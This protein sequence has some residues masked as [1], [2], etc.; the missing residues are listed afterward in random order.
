MN[1]IH[2][3]WIPK[4]TQDFMQVGDF[5]LW[6]ES[7]EIGKTENLTLHPQHLPQ[8][9][10][11]EFLKN[12]LAFG[13]V[14]T[15]QGALLSLLLPTYAGKPLPSQELQYSEI[16]DTVILQSWQ[17]YAYPLPVPLKAINNI[18]FLCCYQASNSRIGSDFLFWYYFSQSLKQILA[19]DQYI[20]L[21]LSKKAGAKIEL[22]RRWQLVSSNYESLI[23]AA[24]TQMPLAC[25]QQHQPESLLRHFAE[26]VIDE[27]ITVA[28][29]EI[30]QIFTKKIQGDFL[31]TIL[32]HK[33]SAESIAICQQLPDDFIHWQ[34]WQQ[35]LLGTQVKS[36]LHMGFQLLEANAEAI[37]QWRLVFF[38]SSHNDPSLKL[39]LADFW[40]H[41]DHFHE[42]LQQQFGAAIEQQILIN[43]AQ[44][45][46]IYPKCWQGM[47]GAEPDSVQL[48]MDEAFEFLKESAWILEDAGFKVIIPAWLTPKG[49]RRAKVRLRS[50]GKTKSAPASSQAYFSMETL[51]DY[52]Y[53]LAIGDETLTPEEWQQLVDAKVPLIYFRGQWMELDRDNMQDML[54]FIQQQNTSVPELSVQELLKKLAEDAD[55]FELDVHD[56]LAKMLAKLSDNSQ[57][58][59][60]DNPAGLNAELRDYQKRGVAWL[61]Y[62][63][64]LGLNGCLADDMGLGKTMQVISLLVMEREQTKPGPTLLIAPTSVIGNWQKEIEK[65]A[66]QLTTLIHHGSDREQAVNAFK[67]RCLQHDLLITSYTLARK[68]SKLLGALHWHRVVLDEAQNIKNPKAAQT[69]AIL[70]LNGDSR[71]ALTGTPVENRLMDLWSI[72]N[73][74]NPGYLGKQAHFR[75]TYELPVQR[76]NDQR[77]STILKR[78]IQPF[79]LRRLK[80]D[81]AIIKDLPDKIDSKIYCN[82]SKEQASLYEVVVQDV[83]TQLE[84][85]EGIQRQGLMLSTLMKLK[86]IC[87]HPMQFLQDGSAFTPERSHKLE[88][89]SEMLEEAMAQGDSVLVFTQFT[90]I[91]EHLER[92]LRKEKH[93]KTHYLHGGTPRNKRELMISDFQD[94]DTGPAVFIL[95]LK[96][97]GVGIT[98]TQANHVFHFD[99]WWNPAVENQ[100]T[101]RA[102]RIGQKKNVFVH[103]FVTLG[104]LEERIDQMI[105]DKQKMADSIVGNDESWLTKLDNQAFKELITL[106]KHSIMED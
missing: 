14:D 16:D 99:R 74:L 63:E 40:A 46:R 9:P 95:S 58:E 97:G 69:K 71:M 68:D 1:V 81:K 50:G 88:R 20:P 65:F 49:R 91:G 30:P 77:Q 21:L 18:H 34:Q 26:V 47:Q 23:Q 7:D 3:A 28:A 67:Q 87:N 103:K 62:L 55:N 38:L 13:L 94:P 43:L 82:L 79:I 29:L 24:I 98:L 101:D 4:D 27:L 2:G 106:N 57:L 33:H 36:T 96:A 48:T 75:K 105:S 15:G 37:D 70:K 100:A 84:A 83:V 5:Y 61:R 73:F 45:A 102:F 59:L 8:K 76:D 12:D 51:T 104:T 10:C 85:A 32:L 86:Q 56:S 89:I 64:N 22:Y 6:V 54:A 53:E 90:E 92:Y 11:L 52:H 42:L 78:L 44:A 35:K 39:D 41:K 80:T 31:E 93:Y 66:P 19:K 17:V 72:F 60:I 25:S